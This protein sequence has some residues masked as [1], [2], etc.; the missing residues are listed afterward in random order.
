MAWPWAE[1]L[2][3]GK[4]VIDNQL[5]CRCA[6]RPQAQWG[7]WHGWGFC[8]ECVELLGWDKEFE[9]IEC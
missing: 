6:H 4:F 8:V 9:Y 3:V 7:S 1:A 2:I 5:C